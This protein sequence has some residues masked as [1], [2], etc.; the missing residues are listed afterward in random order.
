[1]AHDER[2]AREFEAAWQAAADALEAGCRRR[3]A[4]R[5]RI[6]LLSRRGFLW[7]AQPRAPHSMSVRTRKRPT[8]PRWR[9]T[10]AAGGKNAAG[11]GA[12]TAAVREQ[13]ILALLSEPTIGQAAARCGI[14]ERTL[15]RWLT[16]D[17]A[18]QA[19]YEAA[20]QATFQAAISRIPAFTVRAVDTLAALLADKEPPA[21]RL[22]AARTVAD[23]GLHQYDAENDPEEAGR[24]RS[25]SRGGR[26]ALPW[27]TIRARVERLAAV[28]LAGAEPMIISWRVSELALP[29]LRHRCG[30]P[31]QGARP[32]GGPRQ[33]RAGRRAGGLLRRGADDVPA[34][35]RAAADVA[36]SPMPSPVCVALEVIWPLEPVR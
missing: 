21:L 12:K 5:R 1:M 15:Q 4:R 7:R 11:H 22:G 16:E 26:Y 19:E 28:G 33:S 30:G 18:F 14:G 8:P 10:A 35:T 34:L 13:A 20:R 23:I 25:A 6:R 27:I 31:R 3:A 9:Q 29:G 36:P 2:F 17:A 32:G 24:D